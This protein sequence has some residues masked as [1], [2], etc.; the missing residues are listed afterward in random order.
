MAQKTC[1]FFLAFKLF[2]GAGNA[3]IIFFQLIF[4]NLFACKLIGRGKIKLLL[5]Y[6]LSTS[7]IVLRIT[8]NKN[9]ITRLLKKWL[10]K[11]NCHSYKKNIKNARLMIT[12]NT[13]K[14]KTTLPLETTAEWNF[15]AIQLFFFFSQT[16][17]HI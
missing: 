2:Q 1:I 10:A 9:K 13:G 4:C 11:E 3:L 17:Y 14:W 7:K 6:F 12:T 8:F 16:L 5:L 15:D